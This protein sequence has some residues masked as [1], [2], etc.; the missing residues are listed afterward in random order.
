MNNIIWLSPKLKLRKL[1]TG[2]DK[3]VGY[4]GKKT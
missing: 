3:M 1:L 2:S 4:T